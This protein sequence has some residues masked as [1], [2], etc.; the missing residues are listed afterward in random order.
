MFR[1]LRFSTKLNISDKFLETAEKCIFLGY[2][3]KKKGYELLCLDKKNYS[4]DV[5]FYEPIFLL[6]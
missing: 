1:C 6:K 4:M 5:K 2:S 3:L